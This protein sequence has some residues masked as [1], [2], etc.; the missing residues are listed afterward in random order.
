MACMALHF[1]LQYEPGD[2]ACS[3][4]YRQ[5][6]QMPLAEDIAFDVISNTICSSAKLTL[7]FH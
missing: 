7:P 5:T 2:R 3:L 1:A 6:S 4:L